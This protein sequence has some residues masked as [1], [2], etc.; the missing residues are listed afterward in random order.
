M[1]SF[2]NLE[3]GFNEFMD[4]HDWQVREKSRQLC[5]VLLLIIE[6]VLYWPLKMK[7]WN[8]LNYLLYVLTPYSILY[9]TGLIVYE[10]LDWLYCRKYW[11]FL[12]RI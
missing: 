5:H 7:L 8:L 3:K 4:S 9:C 12:D 10:W 1:Q 6:H 11:L 2:I